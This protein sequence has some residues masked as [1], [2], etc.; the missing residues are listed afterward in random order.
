M[1][2]QQSQMHSV[3]ISKRKNELWITLKTLANQFQVLSLKKCP[4]LVYEF[5]LIIDMIM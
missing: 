3:S 5:A 4:A 2:I 1:V